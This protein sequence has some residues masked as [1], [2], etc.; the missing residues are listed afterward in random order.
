MDDHIAKIV[1]SILSINVV[2]CGIAW[3]GTGHVLHIMTELTDSPLARHPSK[4]S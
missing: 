3:D 1:I 4:D 2:Y